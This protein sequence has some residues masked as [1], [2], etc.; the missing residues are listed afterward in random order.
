MNGQYGPGDTVLGN[1][2]LG[3]LIGEGSFGRVFEAQREDFGT[4][5]KSAIKI[6][7]IPKN[8]AELKNVRA[9][10]MDDDS[11][12]A[13]FTGI[14]ED[15]LREFELMSKLKGTANVVGYADH[16][17]T[18]HT[19]GIG[20]DIMIR[21]ELLTPL[22]DSISQNPLDSRAVVK[23]GT[24]VCRALELCAR[25][26]IIHRDIKPE[27]IFISELGDY[28]L[29]DFGIAR[30]VGKTTGNMTKVGT[31]TYM[32]PEIHRQS[33]YGPGVDIYSLGIVMYRLLNDNRAPF[34]PEYPAPITIGDRE[35][36]LARRLRGERLPAPKNAGA[37]LA[38]IILK[39][40]AFDPKD[41][42]GDPAQ[43]RRELESAPARDPQ[44]ATNAT[45][46]LFAETTDAYCSRCGAKLKDSAVFCTSCGARQGGAFAPD[47]EYR[48]EPA[49][50]SARPGLR[51][52]K[53]LPIAAAILLPVAAAAA[54][55]FIL[56]SS[57]VFGKQN[58]GGGANGGG[59]DTTGESSASAPQEAGT[60][61]GGEDLPG[62]AAQTSD[63]GEP[64]ATGAEP[65]Y[66]SATPTPIPAQTPAPH[67]T[68]GV[69]P[70]KTPTSTSQP[71]MSEDEAR[72]I[73]SA[74]LAA[75][76][77]PYQVTLSPTAS[78]NTIS[79]AE[80]FSIPLYSTGML[81]EII[82]DRTTGELF[83]LVMSGDMLIRSPL[84]EWYDNT[85][86]TV[87]PPA[88]VTLDEAILD[89]I[90]W[91]ML[92][93]VWA[94]GRATVFERDRGSYV[95]TMQ[96]REGNYRIVEPDFSYINGVFTIGF[97]TTSSRYY[98]NEDRT[99]YYGNET[100]TWSFETD[101]YY[102][103]MS[104]SDVRQTYDLYG[105]LSRYLLLTIHVYWRDGGTAT[106]Y[107][108]S[109][110][111]WMLNRRGG[112]F[113]TVYPVISGDAN[114]T[115]ISFTDSSDAYALNSGGGGTYGGENCTWDYAY[116]SG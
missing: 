85:T 59:S 11:V 57:N 98:L 22:L 106:F 6:I 105:A 107:R 87:E 18:R 8:E 33:E 97:P 89:T 44:R 110:G 1:W 19:N 76:P 60:S 13:Y 73:L 75:H 93:A 83:A 58:A 46:R 45:E 38:A 114:Q 54:V 24:D 55:F 26:D 21:M 4:V 95:W 99:G 71:L 14:V 100:L 113:S 78:E 72:S 116:S 50:D 109:N 28:K 9:E 80:C 65:A 77:F 23:L 47:G 17:V 20:W 34:L 82:V 32:A 96:S 25:F 53:I 30:T 10:G 5:Y 16:T 51:K 48:A 81:T 63:Y 37:E 27:N 86:V 15:F 35:E 52:R 103:K 94:D 115:V 56:S 79:G 43:M 40:C 68:P 42:Y 111:T 62:N 67:A 66:E 91:V 74:W 61:A 2:T 102:S 84:E 88:P 41:R 92:T 39:A 90:D 112:G 64:A 7:T 70:D 49:A 104:D 29:G 108:Q 31:F 36:A 12:T 69:N 101:P 3:R